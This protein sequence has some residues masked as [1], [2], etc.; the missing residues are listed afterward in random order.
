MCLLAGH[1][2][3]ASLGKGVAPQVAWVAKG[4]K[5]VTVGAMGMG[6]GVVE[7]V[8]AVVGRGVASEVADDLVP[9]WFERMAG[10]RAAVGVALAVVA[11]AVAWAG[12]VVVMR[13][14]ERAAEWAAAARAAGRAAKT[15]VE[16]MEA[17]V[18]MEKEVVVMGAR[19]GVG[20][21][22]MVASLGV[23]ACS[24][25]RNQTQASLGKCLRPVCR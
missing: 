12:M 2:A 16:G 25:V 19:G 15:V 20:V 21:A 3:V 9:C 22:T 24:S 4:V 6:C 1:T 8:K 5:V 18:V 13:A 11:L 14:A 17:E 23:H 10:M 7:V